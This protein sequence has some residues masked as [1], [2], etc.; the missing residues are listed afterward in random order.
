[1]GKRV[2]NILLVIIVLFLQL[3]L[4]TF[5]INN[6]TLTISFDEV[7][8]DAKSQS[9]D[10]KIADYDVFIAK[11]GIRTACSE[12]FPKINTSVGT[13]YTK[14]F[15]DIANSTVSVVGDAFINKRLV[16]C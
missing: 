7:L 16:E 1:M 2:V 11:Q 14:N 10:I 13:E 15:K 8:K 12:Y 5:S 9:Y 3:F 4:P 6:K